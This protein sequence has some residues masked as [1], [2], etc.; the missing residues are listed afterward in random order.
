MTG[1]GAGA[2]V[3]VVGPSGA[4]KDSIIA[5]ARRAL[6]GEDWLRFPRRLVTR[7]PGDASEDHV[8]ID[9]ATFERQAAAGLYA[10]HWRAHG[11]SYALPAAIDEDLAAGRIVVANVSRAVVEELDRRYGGVVAV[12]ITAAPAVVAERL[13]RRGRESAAEIAERLARRVE[14]P[15]AA[16]AAFAIDNSGPLSVAGEAFVALLRRLRRPLVA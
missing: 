5:H 15:V 6:A 11:L 8:P 16:S 7:P 10:A 3:A 12:T 9:A 1:G 2:F 4:G 14:A 13:A